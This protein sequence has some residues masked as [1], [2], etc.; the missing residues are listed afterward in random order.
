MV[1]NYAFVDT[2]DSRTRAKIVNTY[3]L[4]D[5]YDNDVVKVLFKML[6]L[7]WL[8]ILIPVFKLCA[9]HT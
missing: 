5:V 4:E 3:T 8:N 2:G 6:T 7:G 9:I 1:E